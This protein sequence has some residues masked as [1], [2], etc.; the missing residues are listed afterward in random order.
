[1][2]AQGQLINLLV[3]FKTKFIF[4]KMF[5][6]IHYAP[7]EKSRYSYQESTQREKIQF[8]NQLKNGEGKQRTI[9]EVADH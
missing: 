4:A 2:K 8:A 6:L 1:L 9:Q 7:K 5:Q 3:Y